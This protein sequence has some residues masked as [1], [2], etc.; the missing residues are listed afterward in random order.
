MDMSSQFDTSA[1][2]P[3]GNESP[4]SVEHEAGWNVC[5]RND[6]NIGI[7]VGAS[8]AVDWQSVQQNIVI[9][10]LRRLLFGHV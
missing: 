10:I 3:L 8:V 4:V 5:P 7:C 6:V 2:L 1:P 9:L